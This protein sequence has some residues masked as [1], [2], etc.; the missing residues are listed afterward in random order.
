M[1]K[2]VAEDLKPPIKKA[3]SDL[4]EGLSAA[5]DPTTLPGV[6]LRTPPLLKSHFYTEEHPAV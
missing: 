6:G 2:E 4:F 3:W 1:S 5:E